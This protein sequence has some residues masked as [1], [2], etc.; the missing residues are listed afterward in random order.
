MVASG[1]KDLM[2]DRLVRLLDWISPI[3]LLTHS[4]PG[5]VGWLVADCCLDVVK[6]IV[7]MEPIGPPFSDICISKRRRG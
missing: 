6:A 3:I 5:T 4:A 1:L 7:A 2:A